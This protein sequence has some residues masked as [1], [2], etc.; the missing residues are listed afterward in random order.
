M[1]SVGHGNVFS[2]KTLVKYHTC[3]EVGQEVT[4]TS[5]TVGNSNQIC[6]K[7]FFTIRVVRHWIRLPGEV[8]GSALFADNTER[9]TVSSHSPLPTLEVLKTQLDMTLSN[10]T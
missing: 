3:T 2:S 6:G 7:L 1:A 4:D 9:P 10:L 8:V 5:W